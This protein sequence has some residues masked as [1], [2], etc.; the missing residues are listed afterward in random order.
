MRVRWEGN[1]KGVWTW[2]PLSPGPG[3]GGGIR[4]PGQQPP[5][6]QSLTLPCVPDDPDGF[7]GGGEGPRP[8]A[9]L[10]R[11]KASGR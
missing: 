9:A 7:P 4:D 5:E 6:P 8:G 3:G 10:A 1:L 2:A 11:G